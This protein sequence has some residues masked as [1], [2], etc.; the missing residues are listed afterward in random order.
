MSI[1]QEGK[2]E[3]LHIYH[4]DWNPFDQRN[5]IYPTVCKMRPV[6]TIRATQDPNAATCGIC[7][8]M[9]QAS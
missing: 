7:L 8:T 3:D 6:G 9:A 2:A 4:P 5:T 1:Y